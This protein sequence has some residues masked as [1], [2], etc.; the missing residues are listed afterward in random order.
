M[1]NLF[2]VFLLTIS[3][4][5]YCSG[6]WTPEDIKNRYNTDMLKGTAQSV[7]DN[8]PIIDI[9]K[10]GTMKDREKI[11]S[12]V[13]FAPENIIAGY[14]AG[15]LNDSE[16]NFAAIGYVSGV[17][18]A[19][20]A[21]QEHGVIDENICIPKYLTIVKIMGALDKIDAYDFPGTNEGGIEFIYSALKENYQCNVD[22]FKDS[23][24]FNTFGDYFLEEKIETFKAGMLKDPERFIS[25]IDYVTGVRFALSTAQKYGLID[26]SFCMS[27]QLT[28]GEIMDTLNELETSDLPG[29]NAGGIAS[30]FSALF[31]KNHC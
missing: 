24:I 6:S 17:H 1:K 8:L 28:E 12:A 31:K 27:E 22:K 18:S 13:E 5:A 21:M 3:S 30:I 26:D 7:V 11:V 29:T 14:N 25:A 19:L 20:V 15:M 2:T 10:A 4:T 23:A 9:D 16:K